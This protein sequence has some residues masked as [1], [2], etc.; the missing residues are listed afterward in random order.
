MI[1][2]KPI[3]INSVIEKYPVL[4]DQSM[5]TTNTGGHLVDGNSLQECI[6]SVSF[7]II[8]RFSQPTEVIVVHCEA[9]DIKILVSIFSV[10]IVS[11]LA[12]LF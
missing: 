3:N 11:P 5:N 9:G 8:I 1:V 2:P 10:Q 12:I 6:R 7:G 4:N